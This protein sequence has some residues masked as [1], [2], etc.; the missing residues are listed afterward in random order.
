MYLLRRQQ[1][2]RGREK[3]VR[4]EGGWLFI[5]Q[6]HI[7]NLPDTVAFGE[8]EVRHSRPYM[9]VGQP[10]SGL[11]SSIGALASV[12]RCWDGRQIRSGGGSASMTTNGRHG[13]SVHNDLAP[14]MRSMI[15]FMRGI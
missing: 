5:K 2:I 11:I 9:Y 7:N 12:S 8:I 6:T 3:N 10:C 14:W 4:M 13:V 1:S 15:D